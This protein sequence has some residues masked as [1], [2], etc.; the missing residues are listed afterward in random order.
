MAKCSL[1]SERPT[2]M[3]K[4][5]FKRNQYKLTNPPYARKY[6]EL[7]IHTINIREVLT[8]ALFA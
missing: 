4:S 6:N 1:L 7:H 2:Y 5:H 8:Y 3:E